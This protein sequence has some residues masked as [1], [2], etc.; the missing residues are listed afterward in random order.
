MTAQEL[1]KADKELRRTGDYTYRDAYQF[2]IRYNGMQAKECALD[3]YNYCLEENFI[4]NSIK[5]EDFYKPFSL[6][7]KLSNI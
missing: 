7:E 2:L 4:D 3:L 5:F 6:K 1:L